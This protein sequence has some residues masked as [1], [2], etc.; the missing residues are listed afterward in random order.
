MDSILATG[1]SFY[2]DRNS[3]YLSTSKNRKGPSFARA[4]KDYGSRNE[5]GA[6]IAA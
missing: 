4:A 1:V 2:S 3:H 5:H 6:L